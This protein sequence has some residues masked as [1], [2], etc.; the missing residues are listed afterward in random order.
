MTAEK[1]PR[2]VPGTIIKG[3]G[4]LYTVISDGG[5][6]FVCP[7]RGVLRHENVTPLVGDTVE[8]VTDG[9]D[10]GASAIGRILSRKNFLVRPPVANLT[11]L[12]VVIPSARPKPDLVTVDKLISICEVREIEP[13]VVVNKR[14]LDPDETARIKRIYEGAGFTCFAL[15]AATGEGCGALLDYLHGEAESSPVRAAFAGVSA[16][17][18]STL[19]KRLF[20]SLDLKTGDVSR[21]IERG[22]HTTRHVELFPVTDDGRC[23]IADTPGF[24]FLDFARFNFCSLAELPFAFREFA[25]CLGKCRYTKCTH[26]KE[27]GCAVLEK[28]ARGGISADRHRSY[29]ALYDEIKQIPEWRRKRDAEM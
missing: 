20:P 16:A 3:V 15:S 23:L 9:A 26:T 2:T 14:D 12:F 18:K 27:E 28:M 19:M 8:V 7:A 13:V 17:G 21:K 25:D 29:V 6:R 24:S 4:G 22:R 5:E 11:H 10:D 1:G